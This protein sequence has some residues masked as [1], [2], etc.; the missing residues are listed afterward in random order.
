[1][2]VVS[3]AELW[4]R[5][6][7]GDPS[8][9]GEIFDRHSNALYNY[10]FRRTADWALAEDLTSAVF[11]EAWRR[12]N[13]VRLESQSALPWLYGV[14]T[15]VLRNHRRSLRR[16][17]AALERLPIDRARQPDFADEASARLDDIRQMRALLL[18]L[19]QL[20]RREQD[21]I[22]LCDWSGL[23]YADVALALNLPIGTVRSRLARGR[24]RLAELARASGHELSAMAVPPAI[25][26]KR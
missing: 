26:V 13:D 22:G 25:E 8:S 12:R 21:V 24:R 19:A 5:A 4:A 9:F 10:C 16:H 6:A 15:N 20:P 11:L 2:R 23:S 18:L 14:A 3:D 17:R 1:M 7:A